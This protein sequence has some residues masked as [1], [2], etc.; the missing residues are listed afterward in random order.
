MTEPMPCPQCC[1]IP[2]AGYEPE[3]GWDVACSNVGCPTMPSLLEYFKTEDAA[4]HRWNDQRGVQVAVAAE[5]ERCERDVQKLITPNGTEENC[6]EARM[7]YA[8]AIMDALSAIRADGKCKTCGGKKGA[9][10]IDQDSGHITACPDCH[11]SGN[12]PKT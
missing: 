12:E 9:R 7:A 5:R 4:I 8:E 2:S 11:G 10:G 3:H 1:K 6:T